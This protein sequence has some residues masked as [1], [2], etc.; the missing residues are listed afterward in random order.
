MMRS[1]LKTKIHRATITESNLNY[2]G[3]L[4]IDKDLLKEV[5]LLPFERIKIYNINNGERFDTYVIEGPSGSGVIGLNG[6]AARKGMPGDLI[7]IVS[8]AMYNADELASYKPAI[9]LLDQ[10]NRIVKKLST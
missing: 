1:M 4:T 10:N 5:D 6:A 9:V 3:S 8:Y 7:I 2:E